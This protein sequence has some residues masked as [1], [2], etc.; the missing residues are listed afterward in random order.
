MDIYITV[1]GLCP[2]DKELNGILDKVKSICE[3][4]PNSDFMSSEIKETSVSDYEDCDWD[5]SG[6]D[7]LY[8]FK[9]YIEFENNP[10]MFSSRPVIESIREICG[11][12]LLGIQYFYM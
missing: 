12:Y 4:A 6:Y 8:R 7:K 10:L 3:K 1:Y 11:K 9:I 5:L 2:D